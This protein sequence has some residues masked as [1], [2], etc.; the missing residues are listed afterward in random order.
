MRIALLAPFEESVP[1]KKYGGTELVIYNLAEELVKLGHDVTLLASGDSKTSARLVPCV[2][3]AIRVLPLARNQATRQ[4]LN[5]AGLA[6]ALHVIQSSDYD[7]VHNH[8]GWPALLFF[9]F[10]H[11]PVVTTLH[12]TLDKTLEPTENLM[13]NIHR[14]H[15]FISISKS[16]RAHLPTLRFVGTVYNG[17]DVNR[18]SFS[19]NHDGYLAFLGRIHPHKGP[20]HAIEVAKK[21]NHKLIIGAKIDPI[22]EE[23]FM[24]EVKPLIDGKQII[25]LGELGHKDKV[26]LLKNAKALLM[27]LQ[28]DEPFGIANIEA[29]ACGTPVITLNRGSMPEVIANNKTGFICENVDEI[30][31]KIDDLPQIDR[32]TCR[33]HVETHFTSAQ[34][35]QK[36]LKIYTHLINQHHRRLDREVELVNELV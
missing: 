22:D 26:K 1:P 24:R 32:K 12:G 15:P 25:F 9:N 16:Q 31:E 33:E 8:I 3:R 10:M 21:T 11:T 34:M 7:I 35:A 23:Y 30:I 5:L 6:N 29:M 4:A 2:N 17:I 13:L 27:P 20:A 28:W 18:F 14:R 19:R 36:Y